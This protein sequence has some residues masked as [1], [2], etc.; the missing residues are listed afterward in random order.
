MHNS[1]YQNNTAQVIRTYKKIL[2]LIIK[3][4]LWLLFVKLLLV[5]VYITMIITREYKKCNNVSERVRPAVAAV[6]YHHYFYLHWISIVVLPYITQYL[7]MNTRIRLQIQHTTIQSNYRKKWKKVN[8]SK[9]WSSGVAKSCCIP[10]SLVERKSSW[11]LMW[12]YIDIHG[13][14]RV[15]KHSYIRFMNEILTKAELSISIIYLC[16]VYPGMMMIWLI[17]LWM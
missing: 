8:T 3:V 1:K 9:A 14:Q 6:V 4:I 10:G 12:P 7:H 16:L 13:L 11:D 5:L 15:K 17:Y 2:F